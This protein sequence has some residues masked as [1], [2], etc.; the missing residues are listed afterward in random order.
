MR[1][2]KRKN[3]KKQNI[4]KIKYKELIKIPVGRRKMKASRPLIMEIL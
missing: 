3:D 1:K 2:K 4:K